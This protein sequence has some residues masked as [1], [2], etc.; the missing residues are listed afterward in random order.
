MRPGYQVELERTF[1]KPALNGHIIKED[2]RFIAMGVAQVDKLC[3]APS[4]SAGFGE[5]QSQTRTEA[6][7]DLDYPA[8]ALEDNLTGVLA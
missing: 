7:G 4:R 1:L 3:D 2:G 6:N 5:E 8:I